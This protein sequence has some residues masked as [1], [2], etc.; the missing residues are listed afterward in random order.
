[1]PTVNDIYKASPLQARTRIRLGASSPSLYR[2]SGEDD[3]RCSLAVANLDKRPRYGAL[4][5]SWGSPDET[6]LIRLDEQEV[7]GSDN[8]WWALK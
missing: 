7:L 4:A 3:I 6:K 1:M 5:S 8:S 2:S